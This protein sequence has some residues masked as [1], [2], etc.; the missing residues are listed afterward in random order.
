MKLLSSLF[1]IGQKDGCLIQEKD[2]GEDLLSRLP[3]GKRF[4]IPE[5]QDIVMYLS[6]LEKSLMVLIC[7]FYRLG[8]MSQD[9]F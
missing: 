8:H 3:E 5:I 4:S 6:K 1:V 7:V 9:N 2:F